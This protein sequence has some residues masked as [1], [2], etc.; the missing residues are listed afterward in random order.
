MPYLQAL[1]LPDK[2]PPNARTREDFTY[3]GFAMLAE[4]EIAA[5][6]LVCA[7]EFDQIPV[8]LVSLALHHIDAVRFIVVAQFVYVVLESECELDLRLISLRYAD[9]AL[10]ILVSRDALDRSD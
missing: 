1:N 10:K 2:L 3:L 8:V 7:A 9:F 5:K 6:L 4:G